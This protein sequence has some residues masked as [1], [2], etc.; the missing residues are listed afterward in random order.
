MDTAA[1]HVELLSRSR[2]R[3]PRPL[4]LAAVWTLVLVAAL[5]IVPYAADHL[6]VAV[7]IPA[8][9]AVAIFAARRP[10]AA[11]IG[12]L[13]L[14]AIL[15]SV[16]AYTG[17]NPRAVI[18]LLLA[19]LWIAVVVRFVTTKRTNRYFLWPAILACLLYLFVTALEIFTASSV[20][21]GLL[22]FHAST[23]YILAFPLLAYAGWSRETYRR[24]ARGFVLVAV[25]VAAYAVLRWGI[26]PSGPE[27]TF[28]FA[29][30]VLI[31]GQLRDVG[32]FSS[33]HQLA[34]WTGLMAPFCLAFA[35][36]SSGRWRLAGGLGMVLCVFAVFAT[37]VRTP[38]IG[39]A[40][41][42]LCVLALYAASR[43]FRV[44]LVAV[45]A[46]VIVLLGAGALAFGL[47]A[48]SPGITQRYEQILHPE[49]DPGY[50]S[51][52]NK[53]SAVTAD[54]GKHPF[55]Q[56]LGTA[57]LAQQQSG[58]Y[59]TIA[60]LNVDSSYLKIA[61]EQ[62]LIVMVLFVAAFVLLLLRLG[63]GAATSTDP[64]LAS[65][66]MG[67]TGALAAMLVIFYTGIY[68]EAVPVVAGWM[69]LGLGLSGLV[70]V[71]AGEDPDAVGA[72]A[73]E[74]SGIRMGVGDIVPNPP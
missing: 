37:A 69:V 73:P 32:S 7:A 39:M 62:G 15:G 51:R 42:M 55:G 5:L 24:I 19:G 13:I 29:H 68:T 17:V 34:L 18:D 56:G 35:L 58:P 28:A 22:S 4:R 60:S 26:G 3:I 23:W 12:V 36:A 70:C 74:R 43:A 46:S 53:W 2:L 47:A 1:Q 54:I 65:L 6:K 38:L 11:V 9:L 71:P 57:G 31:N 48:G 72:P 25:L 66:A 20:S 14:S 45:F 44:K 27:R 40:I 49:Q 52:Q 21:L 16:Q 30:S 64:E 10:A 50:V 61:Y 63:A 41:G 8:A 33:G 67:A 59:F